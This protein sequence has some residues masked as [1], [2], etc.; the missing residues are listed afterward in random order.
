VVWDGVEVGGGEQVTLTVWVTAGGGVTPGRW[1]T[2][3]AVFRWEEAGAAQIITATEM[4]YLD[5][6]PE[7]KYY[8]Y[9]PVVVRGE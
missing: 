9:L 7:D 2:N 6:P 8:V 1:L 4:S 5:I 3:V